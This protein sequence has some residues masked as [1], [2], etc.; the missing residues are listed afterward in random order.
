MLKIQYKN[1]NKD[2]TNKMF[3]TA[4]IK[5]GKVSFAISNKNLLRQKINFKINLYEQSMQLI[6]IHTCEFSLVLY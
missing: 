3:F 2:L 4:R 1:F 5:F 6:R